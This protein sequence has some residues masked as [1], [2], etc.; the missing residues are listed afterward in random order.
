MH[1]NTQNGDRSARWAAESKENPQ[2][3]GLASSVW[4]QESK[5]GANGNF[6]VETVE[7]RVA[8]ELFG[9]TLYPN[10]AVH[11]SDPRSERSTR[12]GPFGGGV[13]SVTTRGWVGAHEY[14]D[15]GNISRVAVG[16]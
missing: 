16:N 12:V 6:K 3:R 15:S 2:R 8:P 5:D 11:R 4:S 14:L 9:Q 1:G 13:S 7:C 10:G